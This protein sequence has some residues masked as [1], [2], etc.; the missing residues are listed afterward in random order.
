MGL[1]QYAIARRGEPVE[2]EGRKEYPDQR[3]LAY[4]RKHPN[5]EGWMSDLYS[6]KGGTEEFNCQEV[7]LTLEDL[8]DLEKAINFKEMP[9]TSGFFF[10]D[11]SDE[12]YREHDLEFIKDARNAIKDGYR[13]F[14]TSWW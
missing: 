7:E 9:E 10:G 1:D 2:K 13:V 11:D 4:W 6:R 12:Y 3:E 14:Y 5:L 8:E